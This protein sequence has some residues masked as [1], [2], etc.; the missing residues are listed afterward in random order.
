[1]NMQGAKFAAAESLGVITLLAVL[2]GYLYGMGRYWI[3]IDCIFLMPVTIVAYLLFT[4]L[5]QKRPTAR[6][7]WIMYSAKLAVVVGLLLL[8]PVIGRVI[9]YLVNG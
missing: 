9:A 4:W 3:Y 2:F 5:S 6:G 1:M 7:Y 8:S